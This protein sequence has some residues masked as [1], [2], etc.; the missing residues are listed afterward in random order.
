MR[1]K[2]AEIDG[3]INSTTE[4]IDLQ[5]VFRNFFMITTISTSFYLNCEVGFE[6]ASDSLEL[7]KTEINNKYCASSKSFD[8]QLAR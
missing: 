7:N 8:L 1:R 2:V 5:P 3:K 6:I 4:A